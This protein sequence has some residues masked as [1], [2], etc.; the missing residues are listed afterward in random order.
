MPAAWTASSSSRSGQGPFGRPLH[1]RD[2][3]F[4]PIDGTCFVRHS[5]P[6]SHGLQD[7]L[8]QSGS[9]PGRPLRVGRSLQ[10]P[11]GSVC[12][13]D[14]AALVHAKDTVTS[15]LLR[16]RASAFSSIALIS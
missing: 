7:V 4:E 11:T 1:G 5:F 2:E 14:P 15:G 3:D 9:S 10:L 12:S 16:M 13:P 8:R 6:E